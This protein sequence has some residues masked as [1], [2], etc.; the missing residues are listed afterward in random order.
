MIDQCYHQRYGSRNSSAGGIR[1]KDEAFVADS[2]VTDCDKCSCDGK[3]E[4][5]TTE[6]DEPNNAPPGIGFS[7]AMYHA[8]PYLKRL[9]ASNSW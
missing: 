8:P 3:V 4:S 1:T 5:K 9:T 6:D 7:F 2:N